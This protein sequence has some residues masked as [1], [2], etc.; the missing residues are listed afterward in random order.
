MWLKTMYSLFQNSKEDQ[1]EEKKSL[2]NKK[3]SNK[4]LAEYNSYGVLV[5]KG[6]NDLRSYIG[7]IV[8][9]T[10]SILLDD[11]KRVPLEMK[12]TIWLHF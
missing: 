9:E 1:G 5:G 12:E 10:I 8:C 4:A 2:Q 6:R 3:F 11:W 7:V